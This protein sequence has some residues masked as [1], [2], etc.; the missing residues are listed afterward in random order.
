MV[1]YLELGSEPVWGQQV[2]P[3]NMLELLIKPLR[4][5]YGLGPALI[6][7]PGDNNH[8]RG[9]HRSRDWDLTSR[10]CTDRSYATTDN[11]DKDGHGGWYRA[12]D[13]GIT[14]PT[15]YAAS[16]RMDTL[17]RSG[18]DGG[19]V[20][21][22]FGTFDGKT[23]VGWFEGHASTSDPSHLYHLH[24]GVWT[25]WADD[26]SLMSLLLQTITGKGDDM[27][28]LQCL[29][30]FSD[31]PVTDRVWLCNRIFRR[32]VDHSE[33]VDDLANTSLLAAVIAGTQ[34]ATGGV[35]DISG[36]AGG[37]LGNGG[38]VFQSGGYQTPKRDTWGVDVAALGGGGG[39]APSGPVD[40]SDQAKADIR[41]IVDSELDEQSL[42]GADTGT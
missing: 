14:G 35:A 28:D 7:A 36:L 8:L 5:F 25:R 24:V 3:T 20:A 38:K 9:R 6:G 12:I 41:E 37:P 21:E 42:G 22:W 4:T 17:V 19:R 15:L 23:V 34:P 16:R 30:R 2:T 40:L 26:P 18:K 33:L 1:T 27:T 31:D 29:V 11:R 13:V 32:E 10:Y 39:T